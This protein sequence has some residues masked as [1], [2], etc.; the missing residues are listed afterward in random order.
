[1]ISGRPD[2]SVVSIRS[3]A[4]AASAD[5]LRVYE[6]EL[7][8]FGGHSP[9]QMAFHSADNRK[10]ALVAANGIGKSF[11]GGAEAWW[12]LLDRHPYRG[13]PG[14]GAEGW[15]L[16]SDL[17]QGWKAVS[18]A[19]RILEPPGVLDPSCKYV[20]GIGYTY[21]SRKMLKVK[22]ELGGALLVAKGGSQDVL[23][24]EGDKIGWLWVDEPPKRSHWSGCRSRVD[25]TGGP[26]WCTF[27]PIGRPVAWLRTIL[28][29]N[30][31]LD[32][33]PEPGWWVEHFSLCRENA[34]HLAD[35]IIQNMVDGC[36]P[37]EVPQRIRAEWEGLTEARWI[38][39]F[40]D[41]LGYDVFGDDEEL[42]ESAQ[43]C[44]LG[45]DYGERPGATVWVLILVDETA[46][47]VW[48]LGEWVS[49]GRLTE[50]EE[51]KAVH[52]TLLAGWGVTWQNIDR[53]RGDSNSAG[54]RGVATTVNELMERAIARSANLPRCPFNIE[55]PYKGPGSIR[56][57]ARMVNTAILEGRLKVHKDCARL[58]ETL[59]HWCGEPNSELKHAFD[60]FGYIAEDWLAPEG[61]FKTSRFFLK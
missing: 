15:V 38:P 37:W 58:R 53:M 1:M 28:E 61:A 23:A 19:M 50:I 31:S 26:M 13:T 7:P 32:V 52:D 35:H 54:R 56:A 47:R 49:Q 51:V 30:K 5:P 2:V 60:A 25:R 24:M 4:S 16:L 39:A 8:G 43:V 40:T 14:R 22:D 42:P 18:K 10:R 59:S 11:A 48:V 3:A 34:P 20:E 55:T 6:M 41:R 33:H 12:H 21:R 45:A 29:G 9:P 44:A 17:Q 57:R 36:A 27:T 46:N